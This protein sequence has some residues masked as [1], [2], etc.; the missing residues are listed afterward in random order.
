[1]DYNT[2][3]CLTIV[4]NHNIGKTKLIQNILSGQHLHPLLPTI[5][6]N[7]TLFTINNKYYNFT[8]YPFI[9]FKTYTIIKKYTYIV[10]NTAIIDSITS[11][12][13]WYNKIYTKLNNNIFIILINHN[14][15]KDKDKDKHTP[16]NLIL[17]H[18]VI[19]FCTFHK[20]KLININ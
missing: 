5:T 3:H 19:Q 11:I 4:G 1:M 20:I 16:P 17:L 10:L 6:K 13:F 7:T 18:R 8:I 14:K 15:D 9:L 12:T 2:L